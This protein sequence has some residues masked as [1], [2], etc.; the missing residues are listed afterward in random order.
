MTGQFSVSLISRDNNA[1]PFLPRFTLTPNSYSWNARGGPERAE[2]TVQG[3]PTLM[4][5]LLDWLRCPVEIWVDGYPVWWGFVNAVEFN[6]I[7]AK[8]VASLDRLATRVAVLYVDQDS[9]CL[10][11]GFT[12]QTPWAESAVGIAEFGQR[13]I[14]HSIDDATAERA[15]AT[16][17]RAFDLWQ[18]PI[19]S[20]ALTTELGGSGKLFCQ[21]WYETLG[22]KYY[23][24]LITGLAETSVQMD[25]MATIGGQFFTSVSV[26]S[27]S[28]IL[29]DE[30]RDGDNTALKELERMMDTGV[31]DGNRYICTVDRNLG[32]VVYQEPSSSDVMW[33]VR[34]G[35]DG[36]LVNAATGR[37]LPTGACP[38]GYWLDWLGSTP[39]TVALAFVARPVPVFIEQMQIDC[40]SGRFSWQAR[41]EPDPW[42]KSALGPG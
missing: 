35:R 34:L 6:G 8:V 4:P 15:E 5:I 17:D 16:R 33:Q 38:A 25:D 10:A 31:A 13:E 30:Y 40:A 26:P 11:Q 28:S 42:Q 24:M 19:S 3:D 22:W 1:L 9:G 20:M 18:Q 29:S 39:E 32:F 41:G 23:Q 14:V 21:G 37:P 36:K 12:V 2:I 27:L 7:P